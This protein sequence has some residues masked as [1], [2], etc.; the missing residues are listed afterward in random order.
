[1]FLDFANLGVLFN[2]MCNPDWA[3]QLYKWAPRGRA[4]TLLRA[5]PE[6]LASW[7][8]GLFILPLMAVTVLFKGLIRFS[9][10]LEWWPIRIVTDILAVISGILIAMLV[11]DTI[12]G[13]K[14]RASGLDPNLW[15]KYNEASRR[16][17]MDANIP[18]PEAWKNKIL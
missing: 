6:L 15:G 11:A 10:F 4:S 3:V 16:R 9:R 12:A 14:K 7:L 5:I 18:Y 17:L 8:V 1:M 13:R 2:R